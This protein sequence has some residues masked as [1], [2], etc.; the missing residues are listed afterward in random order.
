M[1]AAF[2]QSEETN[3]EYSAVQGIGVKLGLTT[4]GLGYFHRQTLKITNKESAYCTCPLG[5]VFV[6]DS[7]INA[8][9]T[10]TDNKL[11][12]TPQG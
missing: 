7:A 4:V 3:C 5:E 9:T 10:T 6:G 2:I 12:L 1:V 8:I 11:I